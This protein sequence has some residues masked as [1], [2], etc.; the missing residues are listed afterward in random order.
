MNNRRL[1]QELEP[2]LLIPEYKITCSMRVKQSELFLVCTS[3]DAYT[4]LQ[5]CY[6]PETISYKE[7]FYVLFLNRANKVT[8]FSK[9]GEGGISGTVADPRIILQMAL[10]AGAASLVLCHNHP[11]GNLKPSR[12]DEELTQKIKG[13][14]SFLDIKVLDHVI[15]AED[16]YYSFADE[17]LI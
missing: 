14:A 3:K 6:E 1:K 2:A 8:G 4:Y 13:A 12:Q 5:K 10:M 16:A 15:I 9:I 17:G 7:Y 11:S